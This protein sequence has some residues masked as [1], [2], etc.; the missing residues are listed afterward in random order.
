MTEP[1]RGLTKQ[2]ALLALILAFPL[3]LM[4]AGFVVLALINRPETG[5]E[6]TTPNTET[7]PGREQAERPTWDR[8]PLPKDKISPPVPNPASTRSEDR[9]LDDLADAIFWRRHPSLYGV[10]LSNQSGAL[11]R[12][13][14]Q[15]RR[16]EAIVDYRFYQVVPQMHGRTINKDQT[17]LVVLWQNLRTQ[18]PGCS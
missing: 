6:P 4:S 5:T 8:E 10:K 17:E 16:C 12:E 15:I 11:A 2:H 9:Q 3:G 18:V 13:W 7:Q 14:Q 1:N